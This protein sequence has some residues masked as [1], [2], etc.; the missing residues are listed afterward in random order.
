M[1]LGKIF[2]KI[3]KKIILEIN[4]TNLINISEPE[5]FSQPCYNSFEPNQIQ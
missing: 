2:K 5:I 1:T 4:L 3:T